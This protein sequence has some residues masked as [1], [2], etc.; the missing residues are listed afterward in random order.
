M[1][2]GPSAP[3]PPNDQ[4]V[5]VLK[6]LI[7][8]FMD[9][10]LDE[11]SIK[12]SAEDAADQFITCIQAGIRLVALGFQRPGDSAPHAPV[13]QLPHLES[14]VRCM[15]ARGL[16]SNNPEFLVEGH[17]KHSVDKSE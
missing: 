1:P 7:D 8:I 3:A 15:P 12:S 16:E 13:K 4:S 17:S 6:H 14:T 5:H 11:E 9:D 2:T 10:S